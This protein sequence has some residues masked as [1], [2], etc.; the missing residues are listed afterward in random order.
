MPL[1]RDSFILETIR[2][3]RIFDSGVVPTMKTVGKTFDD[4]K[5]MNDNVKE[6][7]DMAKDAFAGAG[8][9]AKQRQPR[10]YLK[11]LP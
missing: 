5:Y 10:C 11:K 7:V 4:E 3:S 1:F 2:K 9:A 8:K 6:A